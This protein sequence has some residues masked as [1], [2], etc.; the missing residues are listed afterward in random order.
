MLD[1]LDGVAVDLNGSVLAFEEYRYFVF[2][3]LDANYCFLQHESEETVGFLVA[4]PFMF[5]KEY[6][7]ELSA[8]ELIRL[9]LQ[10]QCDALVLGIIN[11]HEPFQDSTMNLVAPIVINLQTMRGYQIVLP[12]HHEYETKAPLFATANQKGEG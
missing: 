9:E 4:S 5:F 11:I 2:H 7:F 3:V 8:E 12:P 10:D 6:Q 1:R